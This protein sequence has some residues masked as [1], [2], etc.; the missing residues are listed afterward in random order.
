MEAEAEVVFVE[1][2]AEAVNGL[3]A[4]TSLVGNDRPQGTLEKSIAN[5]QSDGLRV[6]GNGVS[7][8]SCSIIGFKFVDSELFR[9][10]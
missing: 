10:P 5:I 4:S 9:P 2:E 3:A 7:D 1:A 8:C 6:E